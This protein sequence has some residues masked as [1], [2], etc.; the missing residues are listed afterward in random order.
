VLNHESRPSP[1]I[2]NPLCRRIMLSLLNFSIS[3][4]KLL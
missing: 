2:R 4:P 3:T 1:L